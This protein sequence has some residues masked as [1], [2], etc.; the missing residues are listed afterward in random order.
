MGKD[1]TELAKQIEEKIGGVDNVKVLVHCMTRLR[2]QFYENS[3]VDKAGLEQING[4]LKVMIASDQYQVVI[5]S[6]VGE[7]MKTFED[8]TGRTFGEDE[9]L[10][11]STE[12]LAGKNLNQTEGEVF[13]KKTEKVSVASKPANE[14]KK[15]A[16]SRIVNAYID[17][18]SGIFMPVMGAMAGAA[19]LKA[20]VIMSTTFGWLSTESTTYTLLYAIGDAFFYFLPIFLAF[21]AAEK[22]KA[23]KYVAVVIAAAM[24]YPTILSLQSEGGAVHFFGIP[25]VLINY[26]SS[27]LPILVAVYG[28]SKIEIILKKFVPK[29]VQ[30]FLSPFLTLLIVVPVSLIVIGP[31]T[32]GISDAIASA[33]VQLIEISPTVTAIIFGCL[34]QVMI[35]FGLHWG[36]LPIVMNNI[37]IYGGD[38][39]LPLVNGATFAIAG[40]V[41]AVWIK[42]KKSSIKQIA[43]PAFVSALVGGVT[44]PALYGLILKYKRP[45]V[46][47]C[48]TTG[49]S[50]MAMAAAGV[51]WPSFMSVNILTLP[52]LYAIGGVPVLINA[53]IA[54]FLALVLTYIFGFKDSMV[55]D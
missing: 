52:A 28:Q 27:V 48:L 14:K 12:L 26:T 25:V 22:F 42:T 6:H 19:L 47:V 21:S 11:E 53:V 54:F 10:N 55:Q 17:V 9:D 44:E 29:S 37:S 30:S 45:F 49:I 4:V 18:V 32:S 13:N 24:I 38:M 3:K 34:W 46:I 15:N 39:L 40:A 16:F 2:F 51:M 31:L 33:L 41:L 1:Y 8:V 5:G 36:L 50:G 43:G 7:V 23:N 35:L 20:L